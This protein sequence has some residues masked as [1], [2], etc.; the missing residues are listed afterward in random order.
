MPFSLKQKSSVVRCSKCS[1]CSKHSKCSMCSKHSKCSMCSKCSML[2][3]I[4]LSD[5]TPPVI[6]V[7]VPLQMLLQ[8]MSTEGVELKRMT[9]EKQRLCWIQM[10]KYVHT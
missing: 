8:W 5:S 1:M 7:S 6:N 3:L 9:Q 4:P 2:Y 10:Y